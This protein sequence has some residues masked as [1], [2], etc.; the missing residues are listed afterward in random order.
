MQRILNVSAYRFVELDDTPALRERVRAE[1]QRHALK[2]TVVLAAEGINLVMAGG[3]AHVRAFMAWLRADPRLS[4]LVTRESFSDAVPFTRLRVKLKRE[5]I[6]M[7]CPDVRPAAGRAPAVSAV[8]LARWLAAGHDDAGRPVVTL[9]TRNA[10]EVDR[11]AFE[12]AIDW[13][14][15]RFG[16]FPA[17]LA[18]H[19]VELG[20]KT[21]VTYCTG[22]IR[23]E[24][25][26]L[27]MREAGVEHVLQLDGGILAY[28]E[29]T[30]GAPHWRGHCFVFDGREALGP[31]LEPLAA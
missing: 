17:A 22:G 25:A 14:L 3:L 7:D 21:V 23:C 11:G 31:A 24:K 12:G 16:E 19:Q 4:G 27:L 13:R 1:A 30:P 8:T 28:F 29:Q 2:G 18:A 5:I 26:A 9:D 20:G 10:F 15:A 6:R